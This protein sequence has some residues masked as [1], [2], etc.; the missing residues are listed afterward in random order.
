MCPTFLK[1]RRTW[2]GHFLL[3][4]CGGRR[5]A[6]CT[7]IYLRKCVAI[8]L[9]I[10]TFC[11]V[12]FS[13]VLPSWFFKRFLLL[14]WRQLS[15]T[16]ISRGCNVHGLI[17]CE[18]KVTIDPRHLTPSPPIGKRRW[19]VIT[20]YVI[21]S[22]LSPSLISF[23]KQPGIVLASWREFGH[24]YGI[25]LDNSER[26]WNGLV[27]FCSV[28]HFCLISL[29][30][31]TS[32]LSETFLNKTENWSTVNFF[33]DTILKSDRSPKIIKRDFQSILYSLTSLKLMNLRKLTQRK[34]N[35]CY[36]LLTTYLTFQW[37]PSNSFSNGVVD[38]YSCE[39]V[40]SS[41]TRSWTKHK[42]LNASHL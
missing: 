38:F 22:D 4:F 24:I 33:L 29:I 36:L 28:S 42:P 5:V 19:V 40:S 20:V 7:K 10:K 23:T 15:G 9:L 8:I 32:L 37:G 3:V 2:V 34:A 11:L 12:T 26:F 41:D 6:K 35:R 14:A 1:I 31:R 30:R 39:T 17:T 21:L 16:Y 18:S 13:W 27:W 25:L